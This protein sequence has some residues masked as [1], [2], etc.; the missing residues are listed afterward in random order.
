MF[1]QSMKITEWKFRVKKLQADRLRSL[2]QK[3]SFSEI[4]KRIMS[5][6]KDIEF[7]PKEGRK[8]AKNKIRAEFFFTISA[9]TL[10]LFFNSSQG[11]RAQYYLDPQQSIECNRFLVD[12]VKGRLIEAAMQSNQN[13]MTIEQIRKSLEYRSAKI[14]IH[15]NS[16]TLDQKSRDPEQIVALE[17]PR[18]VEAMN[19]VLAAWNKNQQP[20]PTIQ[21]RALLGV[22]APEGNLMEILGAWLDSDN[23][24]FVVPSKVYR[25]QHIHR[26]GFS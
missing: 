9:E 18:W 15:E 23:K 4:A 3:Y 22:Q 8:E 11:Y 25:A 7:R 17:I 2:Q 21:T 24:E 19:Q 13:R 20:S 16:S 14:W 5:E 26:Y 10:D 12:M 1:V 6:M